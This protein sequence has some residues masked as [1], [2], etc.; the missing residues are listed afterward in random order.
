MSMQ[1][2]EEDFTI[3][4]PVT[5]DYQGGRSDKKKGRIIVTIALV[6]LFILVFVGTLRA[7]KDF[8]QKLLVVGI[9]FTAIT[10]WLRFITFREN[11]YSDAYE[12]LKESDY[13]AS[14]SAIWSIYEIEDKYPYICHFKDGTKGIYVSFVK[15]VVVGK[16]DTVMFDHY[17][18]I[19]D[20]YQV[21]GSTSVNVRQIDFMDN[22]GNDPRLAGLFNSLNEC[23]NSDISEILFEI[24]SNLGYQMS[25]DYASY[26]VYLF[27]SKAKDDDFW[28]NV[29]RILDVMIQ[30]NYLSYKVLNKDGIRQ[31]VIALFNLKDF[32]VTDACN[33]AFVNNSY[34]GLT[35]ISL[36]K[37]DGT[38]VKLHDTLAEIAEKKRLKEEEEKRAKAEWEA[39]SLKQKIKRKFS[40]INTIFS[41][42]SKGIKSIIENRKKS[43]TDCIPVGDFATTRAK[44][45]NIVQDELRNIKLTKGGDKQS[46]V[47]NENK[48]SEFTENDEKNQEEDELDIF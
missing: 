6:F 30:S 21:A 24:Y 26:D 1:P 41:I 11:T 8:F 33:K 7:E 5:F 29:K 37:G 18:A 19:G 44:T 47:T 43:T 10:C 39:L 12:T 16:P 45:N 42:A 48:V 27:T 4:L 9:A 22:I 17:E 15:D 3:K 36:Y 23:D 28:Y 40:F 2:H 35:P 20:A 34:I 38:V 46:K 32:S 25:Q 14:S 31:T 13:V